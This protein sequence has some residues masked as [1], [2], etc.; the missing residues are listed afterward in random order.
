MKALIALLFLAS[1]CTSSR[2]PPVNA[3]ADGAEY[4]QV[5]QPMVV[6][7]PRLYPD[8]QGGLG[9]SQ[10]PD[11]R[12]TDIRLTASYTVLYIT[13]GKD[14]S[15]RNNNYFGTS[16]ISFNPK[17]VLA[18]A[19]GKRTYALLKTEGIPMTP[20]S[21]EIKN[22][23]KVPFILYFERLDKGVESFDLFECKSDNTNSC[24]N[25]AGMTIHNPIDSSTSSQK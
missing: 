8:P 25:V 7:Q 4:Y 18:S 19:D 2:M 23:E 22:D 3:P 5:G 20:D 14:P 21:R 6:T 1:A 12:V 16:S 10:D 24:F 13:F 15:E 11:I 9:H 17:A